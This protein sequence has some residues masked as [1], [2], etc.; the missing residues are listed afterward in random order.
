MLRSPEQREARQ[1][2]MKATMEEHSANPAFEEHFT[3]AELAARWKLSMQT[4]RRLV[5]AEPDVCRI[6]VPGGRK[7]T[8]RIS[9]SVATRIHTRLFTG[10]GYARTAAGTRK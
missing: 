1:A 9:E 7:T 4:V 2:A 5:A 3:V 8:Y 6:R 10:H